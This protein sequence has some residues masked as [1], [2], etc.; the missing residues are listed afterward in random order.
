MVEFI[1]T[2]PLLLLSII[3]WLATLLIFIFYEEKRQPD[4][5][6]YGSEVLKKLFV[7]AIS[8]FFL[9]SILAFSLV[10]VTCVA[11]DQSGV[12]GNTEILGITKTALPF[13]AMIVI[14]GVILVLYLYSLVIDGVLPQKK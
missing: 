9:I 4:G 2:M 7:Y 12:L 11:C 6:P 13:G 10:E 3:C 8:F 1:S 14:Q 5:V